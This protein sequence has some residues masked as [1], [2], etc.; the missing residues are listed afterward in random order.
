MTIAVGLQ[1]ALFKQI[2]DSDG[3]L[4]YH[5]KSGAKEQILKKLFD[6]LG[7]FGK[8][9]DQARIDA[10]R[11]VRYWYQLYCK[12]TYDLLYSK[13]GVTP[14]LNSARVSPQQKAT[15]YES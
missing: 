9:G 12:D 3:I 5:N 1:K 7:I 13:F 8:K 4:K 11:C 10:G 14:N 2:E 15:A 6:D